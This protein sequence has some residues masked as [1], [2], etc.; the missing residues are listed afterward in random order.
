MVIPIREIPLYAFTEGGGLGGGGGGGGGEAH[1]V[2]SVTL[3][4]V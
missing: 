4:L 3:I 2:V 1:W